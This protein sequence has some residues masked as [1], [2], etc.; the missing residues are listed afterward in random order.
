MKRRCRAIISDIRRD[1]S[2][3]GFFIKARKIGALMDKAALGQ[4]AEK[5]GFRLEFTRHGKPLFAAARCKGK[6]CFEQGRL[7]G[8]IKREAT[9]RSF[10][11]L[12]PRFSLYAMHISKEL[13]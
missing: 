4:Y 2:I 1:T 8:V 12:V 7:K 6:G 3:S 5:I 10:A 9:L 13:I 11:I